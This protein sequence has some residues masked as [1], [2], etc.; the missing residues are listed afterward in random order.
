MR[1]TIRATVFIFFLQFS[2]RMK[3]ENLRTDF[4]NWGKKKEN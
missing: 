3:N 1:L 4:F 2:M